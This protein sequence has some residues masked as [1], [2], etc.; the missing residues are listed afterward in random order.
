MTFTLQEWHQ[1]YLQQAQWTRGLR[2]YLFPKFNIMS[3]DRVLEIG[4]GTGAVTR[5]LCSDHQGIVTGIDLDHARIQMAMRNAS[6]GVFAC[7][8]GQQLPFASGT[9]DACL[10]HYLLLWVNRPLQAVEEMARVTKDGGKVLALAEPDYGGRIDFPPPLD[11]LR[12]AQISSLKQQG[13]DPY[14]GRKLRSLFHRAGL[15]NI[16][17]GVFDGRWQDASHQE[18]ITREWQILADDLARVLPEAEI[19]RLKDADLQ[20]RKDGHRVLYLPTFYA[21]GTISR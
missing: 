6:C 4:C 18:D 1:R 7:G 9:F 21:W 15:E 14:L 19:A 12:D 11:T 10:A 17:T 2:E 13:A 16:T 20:A 3:R 8:D 5:E